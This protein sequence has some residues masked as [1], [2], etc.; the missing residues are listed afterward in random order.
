MRRRKVSFRNRHGDEVDLE[1]FSATTAKNEFGRVLDLALQRGAVAITRHDAPKAVL[2]DI[3]EYDAL[4][5]EKANAIDRLT[6]QFDALLAGMQSPAARAGVRAA[7]GASAAELG[8]AA[9]KG[10]A[11]KKRG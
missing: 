2:L 5:G 4:V 1:S 10:A 9:V 6:A 3:E 11:H 8:K 7:F